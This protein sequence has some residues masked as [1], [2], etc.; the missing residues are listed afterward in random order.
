M[1]EDEWRGGLAPHY[2]Y[3]LTGRPDDP[4]MRESASIWLYEENGAFGFPRQGIEGVGAVWDNH[5]YDCNFAFADGRALYE[6]K[7]DGKTHSPIGADGKAS[8]LGSGDRKSVV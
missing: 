8:V 1:T 3:M 7:A 5:R 6:G 2:D 4:A